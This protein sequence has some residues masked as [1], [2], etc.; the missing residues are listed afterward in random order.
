MLRSKLNTSWT[1]ENAYQPSGKAFQ[2]QRL[3]KKFAR[4]ADFHIHQRIH[5]GEKPYKCNQCERRFRHSSS[6]YKHRQVHIPVEMRVMKTTKE[7]LRLNKCGYCDKVFTVNSNLRRHE[8]IHTGEKPHM[9]SDCNKCFSRNDDLKLH[10]ATVHGCGETHE[11]WVCGKLLSSYHKLELHICLHTGERKHSCA[12]CGKGY[13]SLK[14][15]KKHMRSHGNST[16]LSEKDHLEFK[17]LPT[18][19]NARFVP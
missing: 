14:G 5:T 1:F 4:V 10:R 11:C 19:T 2:V 3:W 8:R 7:G 15:F 6:L 13:I 17:K 16:E 12:M 9:C 18:K